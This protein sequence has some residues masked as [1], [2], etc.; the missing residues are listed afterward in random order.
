MAYD[1]INHAYVKKPPL[2]KTEKERKERKKKK[3]RELLG[4]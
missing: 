1:L 3:E 4:Q 2:R